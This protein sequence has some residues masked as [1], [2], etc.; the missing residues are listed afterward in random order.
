MEEGFVDS[1]GV[2]TDLVEGKGLAMVNDH[3]EGGGRGIFCSKE[4][5]KK[6][7]LTS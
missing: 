7:L 1:V 2:G 6:E 4:K 5:K 3:P